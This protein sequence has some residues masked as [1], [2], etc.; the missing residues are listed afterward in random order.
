[1]ARPLRLAFAGGV[2]HVT[3]RG[4]ARQAIV[5]DDLDRARFVDTLAATVV[6]YRVRC[7][8]WVLMTNHYHL[9]LE[10][11]TAN[12]SQA[13]RHLNGVYTQAF[14]RRHHRVGHLWQGRFKAIVVEKDAYLLELCRYVVL[15]PVRAGVVSTP[16]AYPWSSYRATAGL[17]AAPAWLTVDWLLEQFGPRRGAAPVQYQAFVAEGIRQPTQPWA[18]VVG[19]VYLGGD[20][21]LRRVQRYGAAQAADLEIP[22]RQREPCWLT[23]EAVLERVAHAYGVQRADLVRPTR[24]PSEARQVALY[25][26]RRWAGET[27]PAIARRMGLTYSAVSR[28]V[29]AVERRQAADRRWGARLAALAD[30]KVKT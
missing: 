1:M 16:R 10:T 17:T 5:R 19:Q 29:S 25:G 26:L 21:F 30:V 18:Q 3:A 12:L 22:R 13:L 4:N 20:A 28:R 24:R 11:P 9:L 2:Y 15:N 23:A 8:A 27:L 14:N 7:H 6:R